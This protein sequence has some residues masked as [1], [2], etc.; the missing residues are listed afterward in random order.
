[1]SGTEAYPGSLFSLTN[2][3][4]YVITARHDGRDNGQVATWIMPATLVPDRAR[5]VA[6]ISPQN[7]THD[8]IAASGRFAINL[9][10]DAQADLLPRFGLRSGR[11]TDKFDG[12]SFGRT[13]TGIAVLDGVCGWAEC[14]IVASIDSGDRRI[15]LADVIEQEIARGR[16]PLRKQEAFAA[17]PGDIRAALEKKHRVDG[18]RDRAL[19]T[20]F[21]HGA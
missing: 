1:M 3:E 11:D 16:T 15:Y 4:I 17:Q 7:F 9:L 19:M 21:E 2:H 10:S 13:S 14:R 6:V 12:L 18:E 8:L 5:V 20:V